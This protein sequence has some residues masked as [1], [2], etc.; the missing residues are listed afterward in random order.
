MKHQEIDEKKHALVS[1]AMKTDVKWKLQE[2]AAQENRTRNLVDLAL[3]RNFPGYDMN[4]PAPT[5]RE[6]PLSWRLKMFAGS[7]DIKTDAQNAAQ[8]PGS[9]DYYIMGPQSIR[10]P[11]LSMPPLS[12]KPRQE[13]Y[14]G[15]GPLPVHHLASANV[16]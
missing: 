6:H 1:S 2:D 7:C 3:L 13:P 12:A 11:S 8:T 4:N 5:T 10:S 15:C 14:V 9:S 16:S